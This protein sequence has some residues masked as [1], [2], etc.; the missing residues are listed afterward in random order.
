[1]VL[2]D[3][4]KNKIKIHGLKSEKLKKIRYMLRTLIRLELD[5][6]IVKIN[7]KWFQVLDNEELKSE[8]MREKM[9]LKEIHRKYPISCILCGDRERNLTYYPQYGWLCSLCELDYK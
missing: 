2:I 3:M 9:Q 5:S 7:E 8:L 6:R 1:M 4:I